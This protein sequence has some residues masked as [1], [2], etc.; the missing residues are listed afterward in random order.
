VQLHVAVPGGVLQPVRHRQ[1]G[2][3]PLA[4]LP[5][6]NAGVVRAGA[7][8]AGLALEV[9]EARTDSLVDHLVGLGNQAGPVRLPLR[10]PGLAG[11]PRVLAEGGMEDR[12]RQRQR[13]GQVEEQRAL[14]GLAG[15]TQEQ[16]ALALR[17][18]VRF[19]G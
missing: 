9:P 18:G 12:Q 4:R 5:A 6:M 13:Q 17:G 19:G 11:Q 2:L 14:T 7:G 16:L 10:V 3:A 8:V 1:V 15:G